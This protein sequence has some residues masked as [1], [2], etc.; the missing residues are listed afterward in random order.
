MYGLIQ[1]E[2]SDRRNDREARIEQKAIANN[3]LGLNLYE[4]N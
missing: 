3:N 1:L 4:F 2:R